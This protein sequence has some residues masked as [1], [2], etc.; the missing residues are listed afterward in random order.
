[1]TN[2]KLEQMREALHLSHLLTFDMSEYHT[3]VSPSKQS[4]WFGRFGGHAQRRVLVK[5]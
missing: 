5:A 3:D 2:V 1:M 4:T